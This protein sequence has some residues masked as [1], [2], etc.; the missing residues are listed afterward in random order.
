M[1]KIFDPKD[2]YIRLSP[3]NITEN[4]DRVGMNGLIKES[5]VIDKKPVSSQELI[6]IIADIERS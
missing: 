2:I 6:D 4:S 5:D 3:L 1:K